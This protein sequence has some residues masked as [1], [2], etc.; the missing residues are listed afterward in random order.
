ME[1]ISKLPKPLNKIHDYIFKYIKSGK[2]IPPCA[3][4]A[5]KSVM[6]GIYFPKEQEKFDYEDKKGV[7]IAYYGVCELCAEKLKNKDKDVM[8][9]IRTNLYNDFIRKDRNILKQKEFEKW[10]DTK[11]EDMQ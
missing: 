10:I 5:S 4:C 11:K 3:S 6:M 9:N 1:Y 8:E 2:P 7:L